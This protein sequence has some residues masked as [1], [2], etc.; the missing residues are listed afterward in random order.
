EKLTDLGTLKFTAKTVMTPGK[1]LIAPRK[2]SAAVID[3]PQIALQL[4]SITDV[5]AKRDSLAKYLVNRNS[6]STLRRWLPPSQNTPPISTIPRPGFPGGISIPTVTRTS[7]AAGSRSLDAVRR[8]GVLMPTNVL[9]ESPVLRQSLRNTSISELITVNRNAIQ[10]NDVAIIDKLELLKPADWPS[11]SEKG[12]QLFSLKTIPVS[13]AVIIA[14]TLD[15]T[16][17]E[18]VVEPNVSTFY[19]IAEKIICGDQARITWRRPGGET[20]PRLDNPD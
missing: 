9:R 18:L 10:L 15:L 19:I 14:H 13:S 4:S 16:E 1:I 8:G 5:V 11:L 3:W 6:T 2:T 12:A 20:P 7:P 17:T